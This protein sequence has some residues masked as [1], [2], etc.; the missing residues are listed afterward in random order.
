[1]YLVADTSNR[2]RFDVSIRTEYGH[3]TKIPHAST[4][5]RA[6]PLNARRR[7]HTCRT[8]PLDED[9]DEDSTYLD[10]STCSAVERAAACPHLPNTAIGRGRGFDVS[11][12]FDVPGR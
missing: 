6:R 8:R 2:R 5:R 11:R 9:E 7:V 1:P 4:I 12:R 3:S 10:D